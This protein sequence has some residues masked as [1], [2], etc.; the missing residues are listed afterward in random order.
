LQAIM[1]ARIFGAVHARAT[2]KKVRGKNITDRQCVQ[3]Q[4]YVIELAKLI[5]QSC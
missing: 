1:E 5:Q 3:V 2:K 4:E